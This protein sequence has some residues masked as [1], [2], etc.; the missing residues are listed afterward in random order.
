M[1]R[2]IITLESMQAE[3]RNWLAAHAQWRKDIKNWQA[4]HAS[5]AA[6]LASLQQFVREHGEALEAHARAFQ[7]IEN[8]VVVHE[9]EI[10]EQLRGTNETP[11]DLLA[12]RHQEK[13]SAF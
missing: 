13:A 5:I 6:R 4:E 2:Q 1:N 12:N 8:A 10:T 3:H 7:E 9:R 11:A